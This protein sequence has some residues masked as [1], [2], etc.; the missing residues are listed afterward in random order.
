[1]MSTVSIDYVSLILTAVV[2]AIASFVGSAVMWTLIGPRVVK[3][4]IGK[5]LGPS[6]LKWLFEPS[7]DTGEKVV[8]KHEKADGTIVEKEV[9]EIVAPAEEL[10]RRMGHIVYMMTLSKL[11]GDKRKNQVLIGDVQSALA[12]PDNP[13]AQYLGAINPKIIDRALKDGDYVPLIIQLLLSNEKA[14]EFV[15]GKL[16]TVGA[17]SIDT[18]KS[19][20]SGIGGKT[21]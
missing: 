2:A 20:V 17:K 9:K 14:R 6:M 8:E 16:K 18:S 11:G 19:G 1:M 4:G 10:A 13:L 3:R 15:T 21:W 12:N 7:I 5:E